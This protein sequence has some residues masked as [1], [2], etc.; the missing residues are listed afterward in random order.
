MAES[1][2]VTGYSGSQIFNVVEGT[3]CN[4]CK[5]YFSDVREIAAQLDFS[6]DLTVTRN[7]REIY[8]ICNDC[9]IEVFTKRG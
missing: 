9:L 4:R 2:I 5:K 3:P 6:K 1:A 7:P 8:R